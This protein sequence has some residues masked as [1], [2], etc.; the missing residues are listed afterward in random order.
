MTEDDLAL[1]LMVIANGVLTSKEQVQDLV[2]TPGHP[3][4]EEREALDALWTQG[5]EVARALNILAMR[6]DRGALGKFACED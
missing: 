5:P 1:A 6:L 4:R 2:R 3:I